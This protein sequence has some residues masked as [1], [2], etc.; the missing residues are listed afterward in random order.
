MNFQ[1]MPENGL[2]VRHFRKVLTLLG[3]LVLSLM[4]ASHAEAQA[5]AAPS[6]I[7]GVYTYDGVTPFVHMFWGDTSSGTASFEV[8]ILSG[9]QYVL[10]NSPAA[11]T[12]NYKK[13][14][15]TGLP[16]GYG[17]YFRVRAKK[18]GLYSSYVTSY[19]VTEAARFNAPSNV[20]VF[21]VTNPATSKE[22]QINLSWQDNA[23]QEDGVEIYISTNGGTYTY[24]GDVAY[25]GSTIVTIPDLYSGSS[26]KFKMRCYVG[27]T[28]ATRTYTAWSPESAAVKTGPPNAPTNLAITSLA[29]GGTVT[30]TWKDNSAGETGFDV[31]LRRTGSGEAFVSRKVVGQNDETTSTTVTATLSGLTPGTSYEFKVRAR[32]DIATPS[33][34]FS[35]DSNVTIGL[36]KDAVTSPRYVQPLVNQPFTYTLTTSS[37]VPR[38]SRSVGGLPAGLTFNNSTGV[39]SG[40]PTTPG[41][42]RATVSVTFQDGF[43]AS[44]ELA[45]RV[46]SPPVASNTIPA[47]NLLSGTNSGN[48][49]TISLADKFTDP[50]ATTAVRVNTTLGNMDFVFFDTQTPLTVANFENYRANGRYTDSIFHRSVPGFIIQGGA[51]TVASSQATGFEGATFTSTPTIT[52][53]TNEPGISNIRGTVAMAK[54]DGNANSATNQW[55]VNLENNGGNLD[56]QNGGFTAFARVAGNGM[57]VADAL[58]AAQTGDYYIKLDGN[59]TVFKDWPLTIPSAQPYM[60]NTKLL[61]INSVTPQPIFSYTVTGNTVPSVASVS[62]VGTDMVVNALDSGTTNITVTATNLDGRTVSQT[63]PVTVVSTVTTLSSLVP[64]AG[65]LSPALSDG[66]INYTI[67]VPNSV[68]SLTLN[69]TTRNAH[70][71]FTVNGV[72]GTSGSPSQALNLAVGDN[73]F[74]LFVTAQDGTTTRD[75][76]LTVKRSAIGLTTNSMIVNETDGVVNIPLARLGDST[77]EVKFRVST[78]DGSAVSSPLATRDFVAFTNQEFTLPVSQNSIT[79]PVTLVNDGTSEPHEAFTVR[80]TSSSVGSELSADETITVIILDAT[81]TANPTVTMTNPA[82][83]ATMNLPTGSTLNVTGVATDNKGVRKVE[84][85]LNGTLLPNVTLNTSPTSPLL[86]TP[87]SVTVTPV[88]GTNVLSVKSFDYHS[89]ESAE[90][91]RTFK[92]FRT[93]TVNVNSVLGSVTAGYDGTRYFEVGRSYTIV[94]KAIAPS[95]STVGSLFTGWQIG[96]TDVG[97]GGGA[98][99]PQRIGIVESAKAKESLTFIFREGLVLT[100]TFVTNP[101]SNFVGTFNGLIRPTNSG[102][103]RTVA[104]EG[105]FTATVQNTGAFSGKLT[106]DGTT[107]G[108][109]GTFDHE[110]HARFGTARALTQTVARTGK[111]SMI[112]SLDMDLTTPGTDDKM[113]GTVQQKDFSTGAT[114]AQSTVDADR[115]YYNGTTLVVPTTYL[116]INGTNGTFTAYFPAKAVG[117]QT[118]GFTVQ[119]YPQGSG[120]ATMTVSKAGVVAITGVLA[121]GTPLAASGTFSQISNSSPN[122][123]AL[124]APLYSKLGFISGFVQIASSSTSDMSA[125]DLQWLRPFQNTSQYYPYGWPEVLKLDMQAAA[126]AAVTGQTPL[127]ASGGANLQTTVDA[128]GNATLTL[129][130]GLLETTL[131]KSVSVSTT[132]VVTT[133]PFNDPTFTMTLSRTKSLISGTFIHTDDSQCSYNAVLY[134]KGSQAGAHG[135]FLTKKPTVIDYSGESG[136]VKVTGQP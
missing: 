123:F 117:D 66:N 99:T 46:M 68:T 88:T 132:D 97:N 80:V 107:L 77:D 43:T 10:V 50:E 15:A 75:F 7:Y 62:F 124:F 101:Y 3:M 53:V 2:G 65:T 83:N 126:Y 74:H 28:Q 31:M 24:L 38:S 128:D 5:P 129:S 17:I 119:D 56:N 48:T 72:P 111:P 105:C 32:S 9:S 26:Y 33:T 44:T 79:V 92:V 40:T 39:I 51:F 120:Y 84:V 89:H 135:F 36:M 20:Q 67:A 90:V 49:N 41:I 55:F 25:Y 54:V 4:T 12:T 115:A 76:T 98:F 106:I 60:D 35:A 29:A 69:A 94:A 110:G 78:Q 58:A 86:S 6:Y 30:M 93:L 96:G 71:S 127:K 42:T 47:Q 1:K 113:S 87:Y 134:Q 34:S 91:T 103:A 108:V 102:T 61:K 100:P 133:V 57:A 112:I 104:T 27:A 18:N 14:L 82:S 22:S 131:N 95:T 125:T 136:K 121:D 23:N 37:G 73:V 85:R 11:G 59:A 45:F 21:N 118:A 122:R 19:V 81:D 114:V 64:S 70:A 130:D 116:T 13:G 52:P 8:E 16:N 63:F 109:N